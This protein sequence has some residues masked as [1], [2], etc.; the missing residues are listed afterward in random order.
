[1]SHWQLAFVFDVVA[2]EESVSYSFSLHQAQLPAHPFDKV[3]HF[4]PGRYTLLNG[5]YPLQKNRNSIDIAINKSFLLTL[6][7]LF[8]PSKVMQTLMTLSL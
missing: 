3:C 4:C 6:R 1:M 5:N 7:L 2:F 8:A